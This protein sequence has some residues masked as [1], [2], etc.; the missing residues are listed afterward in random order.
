MNKLEEGIK[1]FDEKKDQRL[2][3]LKEKV[4]AFSDQYPSVHISVV[5]AHPEHGNV[6]KGKIHGS[7]SYKIA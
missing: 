7:I 2:A 5:L 4:Q 6:E 3:E 1:E